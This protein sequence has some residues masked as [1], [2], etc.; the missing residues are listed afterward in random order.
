MRIFKIQGKIF[1]G[2]DNTERAVDNF[3]CSCCLLKTGKNQ[4]ILGLF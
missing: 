2:K 1:L 4:V 3:Y